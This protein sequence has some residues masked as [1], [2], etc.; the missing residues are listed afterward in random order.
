MIFAW[1][2]SGGEGEPFCLLV[3]LEK[4]EHES[5]RRC[6]M[7]K[8]DQE[9]FERVFRSAYGAVL[10]TATLVLQDRGRAEEVTQDAFLR[11]YERRGGAVAIERPEA[12]VRRVAVR[13]AIRR[14]KRERVVPVMVLVD[15]PSPGDRL[16]D[17]DLLRAVGALPP[18]QRA[19]VALHY[20]EDL[21]FDQVA[22][23]MDVASATVRQH[24]FKARSQLAERLGETLEEVIGDADR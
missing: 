4:R 15:T 18:K 21:P 5:R 1:E 12:W 13:D 10:R 3:T 2:V 9:E 19:A 8:R 6:H 23:L 24:L 11:L 14:A 7:S 17:I 22:E 20:L 16:P